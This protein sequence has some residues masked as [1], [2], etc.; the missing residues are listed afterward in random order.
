MPEYEMK[1][2]HC[3]IGAVRAEFVFALSDLISGVRYHELVPEVFEGILVENLREDGSIV[4]LG[5]S[6]LWDHNF[7]ITKCLNPVLLAV[8]VLQLGLLS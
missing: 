7:S 8:D 5:G 2:P 6:M 1:Y 4:F 3:R